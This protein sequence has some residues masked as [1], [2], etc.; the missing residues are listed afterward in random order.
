MHYY[1]DDLKIDTIK[2]KVWR[3]Q[4]NLKVNGLNFRFLAFMLS[5]GT[6][7]VTF[8]EL[9]EGVWSP[10]IVTEDTVIQRVRL[11]RNALDEDRNDPQYI[12][13]VRG[14]GY[15][16]I[17]K[18]KTIA[19][20][21]DTKS[22]RRKS[23]PKKYWLAGATVA[24]GLMSLPYWLNFTA[25]KD[26]DYFNQRKDI[27][28]NNKFLERADYY[29][30]IGQKDNTNR[31][32]ELYQRVLATEA[33]NTQA[34]IGLSRAYTVSMC[35][36]NAHKSRA[37]EA[38]VLAKKAIALEADNFDAYRVLGFSHDCRGQ[39]QQAK[40]AYLKAIEIDPKHDVKSQSALAYLFGETG[41]LAKSLA[42][43][44]YVSQ[45][46]PEQ[47]FS[48]IQLA[49]SYEL[50][51]LHSKAEELYAQSFDLYPDNIFS[52]VSY[53]RN[54]F[55]Q[56][57]ISAAKEM[58][59]EAKTRPAHPD[60][61]ILSAELAMLDNDVAQAKK[62]LVA[63]VAMRPSAEYL[64]LLLKLYPVVQQPLDWL[65][66]KLS[67]LETHSGSP[68]PKNWLKHAMIHQALGENLAGVEALLSAVESGYRNKD[69]LQRSP[70]YK[71][72]R[73]TPEF[74]KVIERIDQAV[75]HE[76]DIVHASGI[77]TRKVKFS[78]IKP[79]TSTPAKYT[80]VQTPPG[81]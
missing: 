48:L 23:F 29:Q 45:T 49:R 35:R 57:K 61:L 10:T 27:S 19:E 42:M 11:L 52:N 46:D 1:L 3:S 26:L 20:E 18:P 58:L 72:L 9:I 71:Q 4:Q 51:G 54:L 64:D 47:T 79:F 73:S 30:S 6:E 70:F 76:L 55:Y 53:P 22:N 81:S 34:L 50:L 8:D 63:A 62:D 80:Q 66:Q 43:N 59:A 77:L 74:I 38:E 75:K 16:L 15:Q 78:D 69:Y 36:F 65:P 40:Q 7:I 67:Y 28:T 39:T 13:S 33:K 17:A 5:K 68:D 2:K 31:A 44:M 12:R 60:L 24:I 21:P 14:Q 37:E 41:E 25:I 32:I 56:G